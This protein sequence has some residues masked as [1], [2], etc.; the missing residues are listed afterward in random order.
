MARGGTRR[1]VS[2]FGS[3]V[4]AVLNK[5]EKKERLRCTCAGRYELVKRLEK[6]MQAAA[7]IFVD[8]NI[9]RKSAWYKASTIFAVRY[10]CCYM[11]RTVSAPLNVPQKDSVHPF[12][13]LA[14]PERK[15]MTWC[16]QHVALHASQVGTRAM[17]GKCP[18]LS[19]HTSSTATSYRSGT[20]T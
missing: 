20:L 15:N 5:C 9:I 16:H 7:C 11:R 17:E 8:A 18:R 12:E 2:F 10:R 1:A 14:S 6:A 13:T 3:Y 4:E 19:R